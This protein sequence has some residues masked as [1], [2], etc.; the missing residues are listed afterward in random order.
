MEGSTPDDRLEI[1]RVFHQKSLQ[2]EAVPRVARDRRAGSAVTGAPDLLQDPQV[3]APVGVAERAHGTAQLIF[4]K[5]FGVRDLPAGLLGL[6]P[7][8]LAVRQSVAADLHA[9]ADQLLA[10]LALHALERD[11]EAGSWHVA[12]AAGARMHP[13]GHSVVAGHHEEGRAHPQFLEQ[14]ENV[15]VV[16]QEPVVK[17]QRHLSR[18]RTPLQQLGH[19]DRGAGMPA[20]AFQVLAKEVQRQRLRRR[21][22]DRVI[23]EDGHVNARRVRPSGRTSLGEE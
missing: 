13:A 9:V 2:Q 3:E 5:P 1:D 23:V 21:P 4:Q 17:G 22:A 14:G 15:H 6:E 19:G 11:A 20:H 12:P 8:Q 18:T 10:V 7:G 16:V